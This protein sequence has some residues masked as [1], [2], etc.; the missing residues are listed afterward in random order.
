MAM[1]AAVLGAGYFA[2]FHH[3]AWDRMDDVTLIGVANRTVAKAEATGFPA[4]GSLVELF[5]TAGVPDIVDI[6]TNPPT[7]KQA[8]QDAIDAGCRMIV[9]QKPFCTS[10]EEAIEVTEVAEAAG[11][12]L[13]VHENFRWQP[14]YRVMKAAMDRGDIGTVLQCTFRLR[15]GDG[16]G[17]EAYLDRQP[18][19]QTMEKFLVRETAVH[20]VDTFRYLMGPV[21]SV[22]ADLR[23]MNPVI[24]G[25]DAGY[26]LFDHGNGV[27]SIFDGNR[28]LDHKAENHRMTMGEGLIEGTE[29]TL[30][31][32]GD[33]SVWLRKFHAMEE[34]VLMEPYVGHPFGGDCVFML[35]DHVAK[36]MRGEGELENRARD[37]LKVIEMEEAIYA[38]DQAGSR[39][40]VSP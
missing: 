18:Y 24:A 5:E 25:E 4:F 14:W 38:S 35:C 3:E 23:K 26:I 33:G 39:Q 34:T 29:G 10:H 21:H 37:Y 32:H 28:L 9:C 31:L 17:P 1:T 30:S 27:R 19:F 6:A 13:V 36:F 12:N 40:D 2:G 8:V 22:Y 20:W 11:A 15:P 7:H 16:Q